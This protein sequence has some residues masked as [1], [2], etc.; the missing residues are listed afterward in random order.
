MLFEASW[1]T[2][3]D[4][5]IIVT[6]GTSY[7]TRMSA[8]GGSEITLESD[9]AERRLSGRCNICR[10]E[11]PSLVAMCLQ[12]SEGKFPDCARITGHPDSEITLSLDSDRE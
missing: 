6:L 8:T 5:A 12:Q 7:H 1:V 2:M 11:K 3:I 9:S 4:G 10:I